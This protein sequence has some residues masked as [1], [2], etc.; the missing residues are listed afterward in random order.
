MSTYISLYGGTV[1]KNGVDGTKISENMSQHCPVR[2]SLNAR[3]AESK[4]IKL[5]LRCESGFQ[6]NGDVVVS[7]KYYNGNGYVNSGGM[8]GRW[9]FAL[10]NNYNE[11]QALS[12]GNWQNSIT[13]TNTIG[14]RNVIFWAKA[15][16]ETTDSPQ[17]VTT[18]SITV[19]G[20]V[21][22]V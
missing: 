13:I 22:A 8:T 3:L 19:T 21:Q 10:D 9:K 7:S 12:N 18:T 2:V 20:E 11:S 16:S 4:A 1:T 14:D 17:K 6:T 5:A 15:S